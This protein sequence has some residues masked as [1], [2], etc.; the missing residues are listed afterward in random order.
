MTELQ[1]RI[2]PRAF[3]RITSPQLLTEL[4]LQVNIRGQTYNLEFLLSTHKRRSYKFS[5]VQLSPHGGLLDKNDIMAAVETK[6]L[7]LKRKKAD[8][9]M[10]LYEI[11]S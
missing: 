8:G 9:R 5:L 4:E 2:F 1:G 6:K 10:S 11:R 7:D 3:N